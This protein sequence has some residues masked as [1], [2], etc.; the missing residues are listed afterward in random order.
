MGQLKSSF[1]GDKVTS[2]LSS[3]SNQI[4]RGNHIRIVFYFIFVRV[5]LAKLSH[6]SLHQNA[7]VLIS[8]SIQKKFCFR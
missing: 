5:L 3:N 7:Q 4:N 6:I 1:Y 8:K 2:G